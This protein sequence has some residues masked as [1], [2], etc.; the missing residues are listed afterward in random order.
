MKNNEKRD[1][2]NSSN[3]LT[4]HFEKPQDEDFLR[5]FLTL[6]FKTLHEEYSR[7]KGLVSTCTHTYPNTLTSLTCITS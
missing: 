4:L 7:H 5:H 3:V 6:H 2:N 1:T